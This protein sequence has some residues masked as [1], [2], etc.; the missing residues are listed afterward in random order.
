M[1]INCTPINSQIRFENKKPLEI[2]K[3]EVLH[4]YFEKSKRNIDLAH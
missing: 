1:K 2:K 3:K 4:D